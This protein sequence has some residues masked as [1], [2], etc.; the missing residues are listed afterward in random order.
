MRCR[1]WRGSDNSDIWRG[2]DPKEAPAVAVSKWPDVGRNDLASA[3]NDSVE[4]TTEVL[5]RYPSAALEMSDQPGRPRPTRDEANSA[6][7]LPWVTWPETSVCRPKL[8]QGATV[9]SEVSESWLAPR[10]ERRPVPGL[11]TDSSVWPGATDNSVHTE[12]WESRPNTGERQ[13]D[14]AQPR[15]GCLS[16]T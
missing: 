1:A 15:L 5:V 11:A 7:A 12:A 13:I 14:S 4:G 10:L 8:R 9:C 3:S 6:R 2:S 16:F